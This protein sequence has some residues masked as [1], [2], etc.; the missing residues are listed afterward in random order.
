MEPLT[1]TRA[2]NILSLFRLGKD[3]TAIFEDGFDYLHVNEVGLEFARLREEIRRKIKSCN[4]VELLQELK[5]DILSPQEVLNTV[6]ELTF[7]E[8]DNFATFN[9]LKDGIC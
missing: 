1:K 8:E 5:S 3:E 7:I 2:Q 6:I 9:M 4:E